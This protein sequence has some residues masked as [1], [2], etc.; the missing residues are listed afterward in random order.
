MELA[1]SSVEALTSSAEVCSSLAL[2]ATDC[3]VRWMRETR[4][5]RFSCMVRIDSVSP[6][7]SSWKPRCSSETTTFERSPPLISTA[8]V[9]RRASRF[10]LSA[11]VERAYPATRVSARITASATSVRPGRSRSCTKGMA[12]SRKAPRMT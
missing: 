6:S 7:T 12:T 2:S 1:T 5:R 4:S 11:A 10:T 3:A 9:F 8:E